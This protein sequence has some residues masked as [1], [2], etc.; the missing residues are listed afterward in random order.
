M[1]AQTDEYWSFHSRIQCMG[2][3]IDIAHDQEQG[4]VSCET[5]VGRD[6]WSQF[7]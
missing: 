5:R 2:F 6:Y 4:V 7:R 1:L 3:G